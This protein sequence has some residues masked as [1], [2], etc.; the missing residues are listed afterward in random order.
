M[1]PAAAPARV[2]DRLAAAS[3]P[4]PVV[5]RGLHALYL[6]LD[7]LCV[8]VTAAGATSVPCALR[9]ASPDLGPLAAVR[10]ARV[11]DGVLHL[12]ESAVVVRRLVDV[13]VPRL[14]PAPLRQVPLAR[15]AADVVGAVA[16]ELPAP[17]LRLLAAG[18]PA[19]VLLLVGRG[20]G[21]TPLGDDVLAG[22]LALHRASG[23]AAPAVEDAVVR[24]LGRTTLLSATLLDCALR[25]EVLPQ[26]AA[27]VR[28]LPGHLAGTGRPALQAAV[29]DLVRV[30]H[31][32]G[33]GLLLGLRTALDHLTNQHTSQHTSPRSLVPSHG[34]HAA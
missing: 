5:H 17:A 13:S 16:A 21:L 26:Y 24:H 29:T 6:R 11:A 30:G 31:T 32:S 20:S 2:R 18:D 33:A 14:D 3:G 34:G 28:A 12:D 9:V 23:A 7:D 15:G 19:A 25:G 22:W 27:V 8:G 1:V 10:S 4:V